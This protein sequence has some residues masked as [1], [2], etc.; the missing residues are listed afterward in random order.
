[1]VRNH[2]RQTIDDAIGRLVRQGF[3]AEAAGTAEVEPPRN[4]EHGD[5]ATNAALVLASRSGLKPRDVAQRLAA[6]I[7]IGPVVA[8]VEVA[9]PGFINFR[10]AESWLQGVV[11]TCC[12]LGE[13]YGRGDGGA[14]RRIQVE[15]VSA[16]PV[17]PIH[18]GNA[19]GGPYG[20][21]LASLLAACGHPVERE[22]YV[23]DGPDNT[24]LK[25]FGSSVQARYRTLAGAPTDLAENGYQGDYVVD[26]ARGIWERDGAAHLG[27]PLDDSGGLYFARRVEDTMVSSLR[28]DCASVGI[29]FD[30]WFSEQSLHD[31]GAVEA[32]VKD[33]LDRGVAYEKEGAVWLRTGEFGD[34]DDRVLR[35]SNGA[36]T[37]I[38][39]DV[40]YA[41]NKFARGFDHLIY[42]WGPDHAGYVPRLKAAVAALGKGTCEVII[43]QQVRFLEGGQ[44]LGLSKRKGAI[45]SVRDLVGEIGRD[46]TRFFFLMRSVDA[47]L[48]FDLDL[49]RKQ[50]QENPVY[51][52]QYAHARICSIV[53][54]GEERGIVRDAGLAADLSL[55]VHPDE[56]ALMRK[57]AEYPNEVREAAAQ[58]APHRLTYYARELAQAFH[59]FYGSCRVLDLEAAAVSQARLQLT[60][61]TQVVLHNI[62]GLLGISAPERM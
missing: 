48:D 1:M 7:P 33:F 19:R 54:A 2:I 29:E 22:Y 24:Q 41:A 35:R 55:L 31:G 40:A 34:D 52:V 16:N 8:S 14:G 23:N 61:A 43:Y 51:Y 57:I 11:A 53:R 39:S 42:V 50:S 38:A 28:Q 45:V 25:L 59:Q 3:L 46:A 58:R 56:R 21:A 15:F 10:L 18:I 27:V 4:P 13:G 20:D 6:E 32:A 12:E 36:Y 49:A 44:P 26:L 47:H 30:V 60:E 62:L 5:M 17:G 37:Y 9:G